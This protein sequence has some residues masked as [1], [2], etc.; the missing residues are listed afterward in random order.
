VY[1]SFKFHFVSLAVTA[2]IHTT[3]CTFVFFAASP[4]LTKST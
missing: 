1:R 3:L 2:L 4:T